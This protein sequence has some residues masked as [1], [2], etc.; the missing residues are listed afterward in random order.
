MPSHPLIMKDMTSW[1]TESLGVNAESE[2]RRVL[3]HF[4]TGV[5]AVTAFDGE[6]VGMAI[7]S[8]TSIS[9]QP[10]L[11]GFFVDQSSTTFP[12]IQNAGA[13]A[14]NVL[15]HNQSEVC[16][17]FGRKGADRFAG[18]DWEPGHGGA[19]LLRDALAWI[20]CDL[21]DVTAV[22]DHFLAVGAVRRLSAADERSPLIF[23]GG[24][25]RLL[26]PA[27]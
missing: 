5:V 7:G 8:F 9:L 19:P 12:R 22:G 15:A 23:F 1:S 4:P 6:P 20:E 2:F 13:F 14:V 26:R 3:G 21:T 24:D 16:G 17:L 27:S 11:V 25:Y 18:L 10:P